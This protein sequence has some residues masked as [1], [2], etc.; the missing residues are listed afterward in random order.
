MVIF[1]NAWGL[2]TLVVF[3]S[4]EA[5]QAAG[6]E[7]PMFLCI[8]AGVLSVCLESEWSSRD[9]VGH[10]SSLPGSKNDEKVDEKLFSWQLTQAARST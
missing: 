10:Q 7:W 4:G 1:R 6:W 3:P 8:S 9:Q 2:W 5:V